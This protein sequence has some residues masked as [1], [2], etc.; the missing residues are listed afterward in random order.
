[1]SARTR[2]SVAPA[3]A[4]TVYVEYLVALLPFLLLALSGLQLLELWTGQILVKR[5]ALAAVRAAAVVLPDDPRFYDDLPTGR[6]EGAR[7]SAIELAASLVLAP[8]PQFR[9]LVDVQLELPPG[10][11]LLT[12]TVRARFSCSLGFVSVVC[13]GGERVL[14]AH[15]SFP[16]Q[17]ARYVYSNSAS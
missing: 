5:A 17:A 7:K 13:G 4:G 14:S 16:Y 15:A 6:C 2:L 3:V 8:V 1:M 12:A 9:E 11:T 10:S